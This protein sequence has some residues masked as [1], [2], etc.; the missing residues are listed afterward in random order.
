MKAKV[1]SL[2]EPKDLQSSQLT[3]E[4]CRKLFKAE[5]YGYTDDELIQLRDFLSKL[6]KIF[7]ESCTTT[8]RNRAKVITINQPYDTEKS[9]HLCTGKHRRAS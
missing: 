2:T 7:Y 6:A 8:L 5:E 9:H 3:I 1:I 4:Q